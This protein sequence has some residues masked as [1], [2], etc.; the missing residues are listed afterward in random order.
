ML[1]GWHV[2]R[3]RPRVILLAVQL[4]CQARVA[5]ELPRRSPRRH[6]FVNAA[7][8]EQEALERLHWERQGRRRI[9]AALEAEINALRQA[10]E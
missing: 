9:W 8:R 10:E 2:I 6:W 4:S 7:R 5:R 3:Y 1:A